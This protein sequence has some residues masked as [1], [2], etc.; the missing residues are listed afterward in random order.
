MRRATFDVI[1]CSRMNKVLQNRFGAAEAVALGDTG[2][3][4]NRTALYSFAEPNT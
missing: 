2:P 1:R 3:T 4:S